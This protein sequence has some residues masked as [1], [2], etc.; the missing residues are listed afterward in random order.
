MVVPQ[1]RGT[2]GTSGD[3]MFKGFG[4]RAV[5]DPVNYLRGNLI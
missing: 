4:F 5:G 3:V 1:N 2:F